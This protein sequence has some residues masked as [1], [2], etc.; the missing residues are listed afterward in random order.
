MSSVNRHHKTSAT[1]LPFFTGFVVGLAE[2]VTM[3]VVQYIVDDEDLGVAFGSK[4]VLPES[5]LPGLLN[6]VAAGTP[7]A[8]A[9]V[10]GMT[11]ALL[12]VTTD[13]VVDSY[14]ASYAY[15]Y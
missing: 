2:D 14:A 6:A 15:I 10:P 12:N 1:V 8:I 5:S 7:Q 13:A 4:A 9:A 3:L 11:P